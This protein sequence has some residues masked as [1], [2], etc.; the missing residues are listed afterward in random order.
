MHLFG[1]TSTLTRFL[2]PTK[3]ARTPR[4][5]LA[6]TP[7]TPS[8]SPATTQPPTPNPTQWPTTSPRMVSVARRVRAQHL[9]SSSSLVAVGDDDDHL[10]SLFVSI[11]SLSSR[12]RITVT[13]ANSPLP[14]GGLTRCRQLTMA[15]LSHHDATTT[16]RDSGGGHGQLSWGCRRRRR[17]RASSTRRALL[18]RLFLLLQ[19]MHL[20]GATSTL[21]RFLVPTKVARTP[22]SRLAPTPPKRGDAPAR[23]DVRE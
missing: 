6:P 4:S 9:L 7:P 3:V 17:A 13:S 14:R 10:V 1:A 11:L 19:S 16:R 18:G 2:V 21:T 15:T 12:S 22:R 23:A 5:R 8:P 20:F